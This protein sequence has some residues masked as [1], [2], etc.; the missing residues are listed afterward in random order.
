MVMLADTVMQLN[1]RL[2]QA[3]GDLSFY[4]D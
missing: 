3:R 4:V 2:V 1:G